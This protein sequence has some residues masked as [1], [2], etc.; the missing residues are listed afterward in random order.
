MRGVTR[1]LEEPKPCRVEEEADGKEEEAIGIL[2]K[3]K[4]PKKMKTEDA[5]SGTRWPNRAEE[6]HGPIT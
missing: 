4:R 3:E 5:C 6:H 1:L 2:M